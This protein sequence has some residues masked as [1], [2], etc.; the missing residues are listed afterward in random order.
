MPRSRPRADGSTLIADTGYMWD[1]EYS[2][3]ES[4]DELCPSAPADTTESLKLYHRLTGSRPTHVT[5]VPETPTTINA[6]G[7]IGPTHML[8]FIQTCCPDLRCLAEFL[9]VAMLSIQLGTSF[10]L[11]CLLRNT[12]DNDVYNLCQLPDP[13][14]HSYISRERFEG[15]TLINKPGGIMKYGYSSY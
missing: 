4:R 7:I 9:F 14:H 1:P 13:L 12:A 2:L 11:Y 15:A 8:D 3:S 6:V 10:S 5:S